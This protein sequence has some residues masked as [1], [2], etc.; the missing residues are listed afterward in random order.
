MIQKS[1]KKILAFLCYEVEYKKTYPINSF[2]V[3]THTSNIFCLVLELTYFLHVEL[4]SFKLCWLLFQNLNETQIFKG[5][6]FPQ[7]LLGYNSY[8]RKNQGD[9]KKKCAY[10]LE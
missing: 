7:P 6:I 10:V 8:S 4:H 2:P 1:V 3:G 5:H 9:K